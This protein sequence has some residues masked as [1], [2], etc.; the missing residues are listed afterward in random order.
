MPAAPVT[1]GTPIL[2]IAPRPL[3]FA[4]DPLREADV[5]VPGLALVALAVV[6]LAAV[7]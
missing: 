6:A 2:A 4:A 1:T 7:L 3:W 5:P